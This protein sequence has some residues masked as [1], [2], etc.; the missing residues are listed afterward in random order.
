L[1]E[2][3]CDVEGVVFHLEQT[4]NGAYTTIGA[5]K[6][7]KKDFGL[8]WPAVKHVC[9]WEDHTEEYELCHGCGTERVKGKPKRQGDLD[10]SGWDQGW[11]IFH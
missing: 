3:T 9:K 1:A 6:V 5:A 4:T 2:P 10:Y 11:G 7:R 8:P